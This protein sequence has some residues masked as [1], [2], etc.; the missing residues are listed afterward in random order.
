[1]LFVMHCTGKVTYHRPGGTRSRRLG[2][3]EL[4]QLG[5]GLL[6]SEAWAPASQAGGAVGAVV[7]LLLR[8]PRRG[9]HGAPRDQRA[10]LGCTW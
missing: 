10:S 6:E 3:V 2:A 9:P 4:G 5:A 8:P 7:D 1:M